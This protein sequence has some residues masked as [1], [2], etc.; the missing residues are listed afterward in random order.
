MLT[1]LLLLDNTPKQVMTLV[2][3]SPRLRELDAG[4]CKRGDRFH[5]YRAH[6]D[7]MFR[8]T[9]RIITVSIGT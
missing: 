2:P 4:T 1:A 9:P 6:L 8:A 7:E 3:S 5:L